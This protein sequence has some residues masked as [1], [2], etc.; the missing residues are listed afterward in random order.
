MEGLLLATIGLFIQQQFGETVRVGNAAIGAA[1]L[2]GLAFGITT[3]V[4]ALSAPLSGTQSDR[5][6]RRW[7]TAARWLIPGVAGF[8]VLVLGTPLAIA[9]G[10]VGV[11]AASGSNANLATVLIG[12]LSVGGQHGRR[13]GVLFT[14]GDLGSAIGPVLAFGLLPLVG[15]AGVYWAAALIFGGMGVVAGMW[16]RKYQGVIGN[17]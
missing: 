8:A 13:L 16:A 1:T 3:L 11:S 17:L 4:S 9:A 12:D 15:M 10:L 14:L 5:S 7:Q 2:A 6:G